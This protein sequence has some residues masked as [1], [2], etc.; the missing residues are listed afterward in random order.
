M[1]DPL[2]NEA[3]EVTRGSVICHSKDRDEVYRRAIALPRPK[4]Y[5]VLFTGQMPAEYRDRSVSFPFDAKHGLLIVR[6]ELFGPSGDALVRLALDTGATGTMIN[7]GHLVAIGHDPALAPDR[8]QVTT[9]SGVEYV[10][11]LALSRLQNFGT[12]TCRPFPIL[13]HTLPP[14]AGIDGL[15]GLDFLRGQRLEIDFVR[16]VGLACLTV[17]VTSSFC[18]DV[19]ER[20][21]F[22]DK[23]PGV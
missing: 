22:N 18:L 11:R 16:G 8:V 5:A 15:L 12:G 3:L 14:S 4:R 20:K 21:I 17:F 2:T 13:C 9:G 6:A 1:E 23:A 10:S 19:P 7:V